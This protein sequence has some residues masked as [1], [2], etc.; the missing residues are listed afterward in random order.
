M[1]GPPALT[2]TPASQTV[3]TN[4]TTSVKVTEPGM[5]GQTIQVSTAGQAQVGGG[6]SSVTLNATGEAS[7]TIVAGGTAGE[8][9]VTVSAGGASA[10]AQVTVEAPAE[11][12]IVITGIRTTVSGKS[13]IKVSG[14]T[15]GLDDGSVVR[16]WFKFPG[17]TT[18]AEGAIRPVVS[19]GEFSW[20][21]KTGKKLY[22]YVTTEDGTVTSNRVVISSDW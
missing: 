7:V 1:W 16:L 15:T 17:E 12:T 3:Q 11:R 4:A 9:T 10:T 8:A 14:T 19:G 20:Q 5:A 21:R 22:A 6:V 13:G 18:Y 2:L